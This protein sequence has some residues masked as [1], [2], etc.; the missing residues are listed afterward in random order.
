MEANSIT[1]LPP[2]PPV[3]GHSTRFQKGQSGN[4][5]GRP[6]QKPV[7]QSASLYDVLDR[8]L[9]IVNNGVEQTLTLEEALQLKTYSAAMSG[10]HKAQRAIMKMIKTREEARQKHEAARVA[11]PPG[12][13]WVIEREDPKNAYDALLLLGIATLDPK[14]WPAS[15]DENCDNRR[16]LLESWGVELAM[17]RLVRNK[18]SS[19]Q[20]ADIG[21]CFTDRGLLAMNRGDDDD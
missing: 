11:K 5:E 18:P 13:K 15:Q 7:D 4:P 14:T 3:P 17:Q 1:Q 16:L 10:N 21:N 8:E 20:L 12:A 9:K 2:T 19:A 6:R